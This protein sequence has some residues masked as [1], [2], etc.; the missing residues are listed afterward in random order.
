MRAH[1]ELARKER[2]IDALLVEMTGEARRDMGSRKMAEE[3]L[4]LRSIVSYK[5]D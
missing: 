1:K 4:Y 5:Y 2:E 3:I